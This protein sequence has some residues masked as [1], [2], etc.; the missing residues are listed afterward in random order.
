MKESEIKCWYCYRTFKSLRGLHIHHRTC[1]A[2]AFD[3]MVK[4]YTHRTL[5]ELN[6][7]PNFIPCHY[8]LGEYMHLMH[9]GELGSLLD[10]RLFLMKPKKRRLNLNL[11]KRTETH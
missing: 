2:K 5:S 10:R 7:I 1:G 8:R 11:K 4:E 3:S 9:Y 6:D